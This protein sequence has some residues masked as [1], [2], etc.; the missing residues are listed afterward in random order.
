MRKVRIASVLLI[1]AITLAA[2]AE[3]N[4][5]LKHAEDYGVNTE[6]A[7]DVLTN[8]EIIKGLK[9]ALSKGTD[10]AV[11]SLNVKGWL[12]RESSLEDSS[13]KRSSTHL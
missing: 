3:L 11:S 10:F 12:F 5:L 1:S 9:E 7:K 13:S 8:D 6:T 2:C 4:K